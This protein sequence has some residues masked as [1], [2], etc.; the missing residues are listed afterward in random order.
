[1]LFLRFTLQSGCREIQADQ[2]LIST[3]SSARLH[4]FLHR[5]LAVLMAMPMAACSLSVLDLRCRKI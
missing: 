4:I 2:R 3:A 5:F 1:L